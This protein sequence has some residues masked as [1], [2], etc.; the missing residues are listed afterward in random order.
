MPWQGLAL[1]V[2][3]VVC[4][5]AAND[6]AVLIRAVV[7]RYHEVL[8]TRCPHTEAHFPELVGTVTAYLRSRRA[9]L[10]LPA[11]TLILDAV[12]ARYACD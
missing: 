12:R 10:R 3:A 11:S 4:P 6:C 5:R 8:A 9:D 7:D 1:G 2:L